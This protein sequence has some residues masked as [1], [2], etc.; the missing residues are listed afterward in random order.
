MMGAHSRP[1]NHTGD[2]S[3]HHQQQ[4]DETETRPSASPHP[5]GRMHEKC[6]QTNYTSPRT[7]TRCSTATV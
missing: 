5:S 4:Q 1:P 3:H 2:H 7:T 6:S